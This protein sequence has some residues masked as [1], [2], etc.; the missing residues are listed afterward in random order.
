M[1]RTCTNDV[2][3]T[4]EKRSEKFLDRVMN[5]VDQKAAKMSQQQFDSAKDKIKKI[6]DRVNRRRESF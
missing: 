4:P 6:V 5:A 2:P 3:S 1:H